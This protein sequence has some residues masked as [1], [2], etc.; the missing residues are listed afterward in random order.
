MNS[1]GKI[2]RT[3]LSLSALGIILVCLAVSWGISR[4]ARSGTLCSGIEVSITDSTESRFVSG[5]DILEYISEDYG[6]TEGIPVENLDLDRM[7]Q[8]LDSRS[9]VLKSE[10]YCTK[11]GILHID[12]TQREPVMR[13]QKGGQG[14]YADERGYVFPLKPGKASYVIVIDGNIPI[15]TG[16]AGKGKAVSGKEKEWLDR[17]GAMVSYMNRHKVWNR[18]IV[19]IHVSD[20]G[21]LILIPREGREKFIF[22]KPEKIEEKFELMELYYSA[23]VPSGEKD[24]YGTVDVRYDKQIICK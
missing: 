7:E 15:E 9:A 1:S 2:I 12:V 22:G 19:Q 14:F 24:R 3:I 16:D 20:N 13:F 18:S 17:M 10:A 5:K 8:M 6:K 21:D 4:S 11:D 23:V